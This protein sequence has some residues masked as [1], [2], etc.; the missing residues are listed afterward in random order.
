M[1]MMLWSAFIRLS[2]SC[3]FHVYYMLPDSSRGACAASLSRLQMM[4]LI[5]TAVNTD[6]CP[7]RCTDRN[8]GLSTCQG[9]LRPNMWSPE[10]RLGLASSGKSGGS[11][12][13]SSEE[14][15]FHTASMVIR[16]TTHPV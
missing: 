11:A 5:S 13:M 2:R 9:Y 10:V 16:P 7:R 12:L 1:H 3:E 8:S 4:P 14:A 15:R 6:P